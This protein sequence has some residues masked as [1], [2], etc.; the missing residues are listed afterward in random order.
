MYLD[1]FKHLFKGLDRAYGQLRSG[2]DHSTEKGTPTDSVWESHLKGDVGI[3]IIPIQDD[4]QCCWGAIDIDVKDISH[5]E[6]VQRVQKLGLPLYVCASKGK[7]YHCYF[8]YIHPG[9]QAPLLRGRLRMW[10]TALGYPSA[11][12]FPKQDFLT[13]EQI[14][15]YINLPYFGGYTETTRYCM[16]PEGKELSL[17][18][19]LDYVQ[20]W[21][22]DVPLPLPSVSGNFDDGPPC[23]QTLIE[24]GIPPGQR[25]QAMYNIGIFLRKAYPEAWREQMRNINNKILEKSLSDKELNT[26][27][28]SLTKR[29]YFYKCDEDPIAS[30]C[31]R[32]ICL[33]KKFGIGHEKQEEA[34]A[35]FTHPDYQ[36]LE[37]LDTKPPRYYLTVNGL[38]LDLSTDELMSW[39]RLRKCLFEAL[40]E[41]PASTPKIEKEWERTLAGLTSK[42]IIHDAP[43]EASDS[44]QVIA[45]LE[46][47]AEQCS[48]D[49]T[50]L[51]RGDPYWEDNLVYISLSSFSQYLYAKKIKRF[52]TNELVSLLRLN[53]WR[54]ITLQKEKKKY[55]L[56]AKEHEKPKT[57][58]IGSFKIVE[59][60]KENH[61]ERNYAGSASQT[62]EKTT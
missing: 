49:T 25:N 30:V 46:G 61:D 55:R 20:P 8:F 21:N 3:G 27:M 41:L 28:K 29:E 48:A 45:E 36:A 22:P 51:L 2:K 33:T 10:A 40:D 4:G 31:Q 52:E 59:V 37:K 19:F 62:D 11:E 54:D 56:W 38:R 18:E 13:G 35:G 7:G 34:A 14:G 9:K 12:V 26:I 47:W 24:K 60:P 53:G 6:L 43:P 32:D 5:L 44:G 23:L 15:N 42:I 57:S 50:S 1:R 16:T 39:F 17:K 58:M